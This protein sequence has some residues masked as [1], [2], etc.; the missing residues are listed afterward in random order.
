MPSLAPFAPCPICKRPAD[1]AFKPFC[2]GR[3]RD[4][5]LHRWM[6]GV[7]AIPVTHDDEDED[8]DGVRRDPPAEG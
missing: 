5:D 1:E 4:V 3:C 7:Y 8:G 6:A 2:S